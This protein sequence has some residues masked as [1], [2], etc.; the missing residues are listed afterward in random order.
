MITAS[1]DKSPDEEHEGMQAI[2]AIQQGNVTAL[3]EIL[4]HEPSLVNTPQT[5][6]SS[7]IDTTPRGLQNS[8]RIKELKSRSRDAAPKA[9]S[10]C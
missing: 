9:R 5:S 4:D 1:Q 7:K 6:S 8:M 2:Q 3:V 10:R